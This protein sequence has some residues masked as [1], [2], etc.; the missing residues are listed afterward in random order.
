MIKSRNT[1]IGLL[2]AV[3]AVLVPLLD[4][5]RY[6]LVQLSLFFTWAMV[7]TQWN[8]VFGV[9]GIFSLAQ[10]AVFAVGAYSAAMLGLY[11]GMNF[12]L[13]SLAG[14]LL[15][16]LFSLVVGL[17]TLRLK[18]PYVALLT[19]SVSLV[20]YQLIVTDTHC[21]FYEGNTC[22]TF[23]GGTRAIGKFGD[24]GFREAFGY[25]HELIA[26]YYLGLILLICGTVFA[27]AVMRSPL[28]GAFRALRDNEAYAISRGINRTK[29]QL[30]V[31][32]VSAF[33]TGLAGAFYAGT[34]KV[35]GPNVL[36]LSLM[37]FLISML[38][39]GGLGRPWG[40][41][42]GSALLMAADESLSSVPEWR[43]IG[44][45]ILTVVFVIVLP[46]GLTGAWDVALQKLRKARTHNGVST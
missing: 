34:F 44:L 20:L 5:G 39:V 32:A 35:V 16:V 42:V 27:F 26:G 15:A 7:V 6:M 46:N 40:P 22:Y 36:N 37:L 31:F 38:V 24:F 29:Y 11:L 33:F 3:V 12:W 1:L 9:A 25:S 23:T 28:G 8:L 30:L 45:G 21:F 18:G 2:L 43:M 19:L 13:A 10:M 41:L 14:G 17:A 4:P